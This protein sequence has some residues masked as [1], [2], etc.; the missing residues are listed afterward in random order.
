[1]ESRIN[2]GL[3]HCGVILILTFIS[4]AR[5]F[6]HLGFSDCKEIMKIEFF[7]LRANN[8][9][10]NSLHFIS[11][12]Y[13]IEKSFVSDTMRDARLLDS[14]IFYKSRSVWLNSKIDKK[15]T[16]LQT[17]WGSKSKL[18]N[19]KLLKKITRRRSCI[20]FICIWIQLYTFVRNMRKPYVNILFIYLFQL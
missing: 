12:N 17:T 2:Y 5:Y 1:M 16:R 4:F 9:S 14:C 3:I 18:S 8:T 11:I 7:V 10:F 19:S 6:D 15:C 20:I 13:N